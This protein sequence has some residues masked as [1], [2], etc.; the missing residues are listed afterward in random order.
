MKTYLTLSLLILTSVSCSDSGNHSN[1]KY[2]VD[3][4]TC[5]YKDNQKPCADSIL[6]VSDNNMGSIPNKVAENV[7]YPS[8][9]IDETHTLKLYYPNFSK[10]DLVCGKMPDKSDDSVIMV[11]AAAYTVK[12]MDTFSHSNI[13]G[14]HIASGKRYSGTPSDTYRGAFTYY[15][16]APHF[17]YDNWVKEFSEA[18]E[19]GGCG[20]AQDMMI[21]EGMITNYWRKKNSETEFRALCQIDDKIAIVD[22]K[23][24]RKFGE[25]V[26]DLH[27]LGVQEAIYL[28]MGGWKHSWYRNS[29]NQPIDIYKNPNKYA[30]NW[31]TFYK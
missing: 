26:N 22:S 4:C 13:I 10:I 21:H 17:T 14:D 5:N 29:E 19:N 2:D 7:Q 30:T 28:D 31:I 11:C 23:G 27:E 25:F 18:V 6:V 12:R 8:V 20:F 3:C 9:Y 24:P 1:A 16:G 15:N